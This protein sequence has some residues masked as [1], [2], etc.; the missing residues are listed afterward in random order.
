M[1]TLPKVLITGCS[2]GIGR[3]TAL[4]L[5]LS[6][7][8]TVY[9]TARRPE[10]LGPLAEL[11]AITRP[12]DTTDDASMRAV[13]AEMGEVDV[14]INNAGYGE[15]GTVEE[16]PLDALRRGFE[17]NVVGPTRLCQLALPSMRAR[18]AGRIVFVG[19]LGGK[20]TL[21]AAAGYHVTK[22]ALE[23]LADALRFEVADFGVHVTL[24]QPG[25][26]RTEFGST[27]IETLKRN[28]SAEGA[29]AHLNATV[30]AFY[31]MAFQP[32]TQIGVTAEHVAEAIERVVLADEPPTREVV[33]DDH[34]L[35]ELR[36]SQ[37]DRAFDAILRQMHGL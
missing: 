27:A 10:T 21:P 5:A 2:T 4:R 14:L 20:F 29:Y 25:M 12:L 8:F 7:R 13:V 3:A 22:Y 6:K 33:T 30:A 19:S 11:G 35:V 17:T 9:A 15:Y 16:L 37:S 24:L 36:A 23:S 31:G 32:G 26:V 1:T 18:R 34:T 28:S